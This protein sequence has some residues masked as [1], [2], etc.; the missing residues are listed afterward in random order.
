MF[1][2]QD[3]AATL[4]TRYAAI[5]PGA[6]VA[7]LCAAPGGKTVEVARGGG[8]VFASDSSRARLRRVLENI[9]RLEVANVY[10]YV[11]DARH[12]A[13]RAVDAALVDAPCTGTGT[14]RRHPDA[15]AGGLKPSDVS[16]MA[17]L[18]GDALFRSGF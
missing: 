10:P 4:V 16:I 3:P 2:V 5:P 15:P 7:D 8:P 18:Q 1:H 9:K 11:A 13:L 17:A 6:T 12:P 14:M